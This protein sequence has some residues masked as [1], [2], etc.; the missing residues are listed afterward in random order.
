MDERVA[1]EDPGHRAL[2]GGL[3]LV[4][5]LLV[6]AQADLLGDLLDVEAGRHPREQ[7]HDQPEVLHVGADRVGDARVLD[8]DGHRAAVVEGRAIDL[9]DRCGGDRLVVEGR[10]Q[11][12]EGVLELGL[13]DPAHL[14]EGDRRSGVAK[15]GELA[16]ELVA[17]GLGHQAHVEERHDLAE[18]HRRALHRP[19]HGDDLL[20]GLHLAAGQRGLAGLVAAGEVRRARPELADGLS[21]G[22][23]PDRCRAHHPR[24]RDVLARHL[25]SP[26]SALSSRGR[27]RRSRRASGPRP[28]GRRRSRPEQDQRRRIAERDAGL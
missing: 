4:V 17:V 18:L 7:A 1:A 24:G 8:L 27:C 20:G 11:L 19:E 10:E 26:V 16:L 5:E 25:A 9:P 2:V 23:A 15:R 21:C 12:V 28:C 3:E 14:L 13:D 6:D 22:E